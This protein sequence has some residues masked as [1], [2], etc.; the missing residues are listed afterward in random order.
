MGSV[1]KQADRERYKYMAEAGNRKKWDKG[2]ISASARCVVCG[3][4][5]VLAGGLQTSC[6][7]GAEECA[8]VVRF[9]GGGG[10]AERMSVT[11][12]TSCSHRVQ[13]C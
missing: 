5:W 10:G 11:G 6:W 1:Q 2:I 9:A 13:T 4:L 8:F 3:A 12:G 7:C